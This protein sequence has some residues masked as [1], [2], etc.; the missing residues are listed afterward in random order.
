MATNFTSIGFPVVDEESFSDLCSR[1]E[2]LPLIEYDATPGGEYLCWKQ[3]D[4]FGPE[5]WVQI[6]DN[7]MVSVT[8]FFR[9]KS[10]M[11]VGVQSVVEEIQNTPLDGYLYGWA[12]PQDENIESGL[13][14]FIFYM[15]GLHRYENLDWP[16]VEKIRLTAIANDF[17]YYASEAEYMSAQEK[18]EG[19]AMASESFIPSGT[20]SADDEEDFTP[21][22]TAAFSGTVLETKKIENSETGQSFHWA[23]VRTLGGT[24]DVVIDPEYISKPLKAGSIIRGSF[25]LCADFKI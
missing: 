7:E 10:E 4:D 2:E 14:P 11:L 9:G 6:I 3:N 16:S 15:A 21:S 12:D 13:Y 19:P 23:L 17:E 1:L 24:V 22:P 5:I 18:N 20:F 8:P 25:Y